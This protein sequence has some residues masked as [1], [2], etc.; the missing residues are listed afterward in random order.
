MDPLDLAG[1]APPDEYDAYLLPVA[2]LLRDGATESE[3][4]RQ[5]NSGTIRRDAR[6][7]EALRK[8]FREHGPETSGDIHEH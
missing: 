3:I 1:I 5:L 2:R 4:A 8:W 7:A 6:A